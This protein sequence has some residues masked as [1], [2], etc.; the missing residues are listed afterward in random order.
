MEYGVQTYDLVIQLLLPTEFH[1][2]GVGN[3]RVFFYDTPPTPAPHYIPYQHFLFTE[4]TW[5]D[6]HSALCL[7]C[8]GLNEDFFLSDRLRRDEMTSKLHGHPV[9]GPIPNDCLAG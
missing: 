5:E 8:V 4:C 7:R 1:G 3:K 9:A 6:H 2:R